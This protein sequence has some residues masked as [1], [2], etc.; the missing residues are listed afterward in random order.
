MARSRSL[1]RGGARCSDEIA[2]LAVHANNNQFTRRQAPSARRYCWPSSRLLLA[3]KE[4][5]PKR[6]DPVARQTASRLLRHRPGKHGCRM[7][8]AET[9]FMGTASVAFCNCRARRGPGDGEEWRRVDH[10]RHLYRQNARPQLMVRPDY[11][12]STRTAVS[13]KTKSALQVSDQTQTTWLTAQHKLTIA[14]IL[15]IISLI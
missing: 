5:H 7:R 2:A 12:V 11:R 10:I 3:L 15:L 4:S 14:L 8:S 6:S 13:P 9:V 1:H